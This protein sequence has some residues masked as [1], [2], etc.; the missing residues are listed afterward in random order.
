M[1]TDI[2]AFNDFRSFL[3]SH[4]AKQRLARPRWS[5]G[6]WARQLGL[7]G[8]ASLT[9]VINGQ[10]LPGPDLT[11]KLVRYFGFDRRAASYFRGLVDLERSRKDPDAFHDAAERM[12]KA[13]PCG[14]VRV[15]DDDQFML[16]GQWYHYAIRELTLVAGFEEDPFWISARLKG[17]V[18][19]ST[20]K[21][22][23]RRLERL[24][25][26]A[27]DARGRLGPSEPTVEAGGGA[28]SQAVRAFH[29]QA[30]KL[31]GH[32]LHNVPKDERLFAASTLSVRRDAVREVEGLVARF[33]DEL[34]RLC[35]RRGDGDE[36]YQLTLQF[37][38]LTA[39]K[40]EGND[41]KGRET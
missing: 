5:Y 4:A 23:L 13:H 20:V 38:P 2:F 39:A 27:R 33:Q 3:A 32:A 7:A 41:K 1:T 35:E 16:V 36:V 31:A 40:R 29:E 19:P 26:L 12:R 17:R 21:E 11:R 10:R 34:A 8:T 14:A 22:A 18:P 24:Q 9:M 28:P 6:A 15:L 30:L 37:V 25:L